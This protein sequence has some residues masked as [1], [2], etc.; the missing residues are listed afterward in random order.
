MTVITIPKSQIKT[1][2]VTSAKAL[3]AGEMFLERV[4][5]MGTEIAIEM[6]RPTLRSDRSRLLPSSW[7]Y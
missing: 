5:A 7:K 6:M 1:V 2:L 3:E 4:T